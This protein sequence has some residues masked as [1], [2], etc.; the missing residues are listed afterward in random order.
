MEAGSLGRQVWHRDRHRHV[1]S[2]TIRE[3]SCWEGNSAQSPE[4]PPIQSRDKS[5]LCAHFWSENQTNLIDWVHQCGCSGFYN[6]SVMEAVGQVGFGISCRDMKE[7]THRMVCEVAL[8]T[9]GSP[10]GSISCAILRF[11]C[12]VAN[13]TCLGRYATIR[14]SST[15]SMSH[16]ACNE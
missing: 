5:S 7:G 9:N 1:H 11:V 8:S 12:G 13:H 4:C 6:L 15:H 16:C 10:S 2:G 3:Y 14:P